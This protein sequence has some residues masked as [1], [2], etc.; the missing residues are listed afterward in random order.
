LRMAEQEHVS[1]KT[2]SH[3]LQGYIATHFHTAEAQGDHSLIL[4]SMPVHTRERV[5]GTNSRCG[6][7]EPAGDDAVR[8]LAS[9]VRDRVE[10]ARDCVERESDLEELRV[11][12]SEDPD[13]K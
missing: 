1:G 6:H 11:A 3:A 12:I 13:A 9:R 7:A 5:E 10:A 8:L 2:G 4:R